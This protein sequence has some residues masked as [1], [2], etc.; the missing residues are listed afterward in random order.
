MLVDGLN[1]GNCFECDVAII[2]I[3]MI[4]A[5]RLYDCKFV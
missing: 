4:L 3:D 5:Y 1:F 2:Y